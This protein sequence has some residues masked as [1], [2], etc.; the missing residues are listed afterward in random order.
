[1]RF[2]YCIAYWN[3]KK[4]RKAHHLVYQLL[5]SLYSIQ[6][7]VVAC[8]CAFPSVFTIHV[9]Y[10]SISFHS[11]L[12][13][14][15]HSY[16]IWMLRTYCCYCWYMCVWCV[17]MWTFNMLWSVT[18]AVIFIKWIFYVKIFDDWVCR[19]NVKRVQK[20]MCCVVM[21]L[22]LVSF[23]VSTR[24]RCVRD[25]CVEIQI[26]HIFFFTYFYFTQT[27]TSDIIP[28]DEKSNAEVTIDSENKFN[29]FVVLILLHIFFVRSTRTPFP[30]EIETFGASCVGTTICISLFAAYQAIES[31]RFPQAL[32]NLL[33]D[34]R[35][36]FI[37]LFAL[38]SATVDCFGR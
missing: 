36:I 25:E 24:G 31:N 15:C 20:N 3:E 7:I 38:S 27:F 29:N 8:C 26:A 19:Q 37:L 14:F 1:M 10:Y 17:W 23:V 13:I 28:I 16:L 30:D 6:F 5:H 21:F 35:W 33:R 18:V 2:I 22:S 4:G 34:S 9:W 11:H 12:S 32:Q